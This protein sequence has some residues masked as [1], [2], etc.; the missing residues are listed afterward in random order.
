MVPTC[1]QSD[2]RIEAQAASVQA[3]SAVAGSHTKH[4]MSLTRGKNM[5]QKVQ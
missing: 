3:R 4:D 1:S 2:R 5:T